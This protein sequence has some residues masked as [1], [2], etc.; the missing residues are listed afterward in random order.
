MEWKEHSKKLKELLKL[1]GSPIAITY[2]TNPA[3]ECKK[4]EFRVCDAMLLARN[5]EIINLTKE[6]SSCP[7]GTWHLGL[8]PKAS[9][10]EYRALQ[11]FLVEGEK[12]CSS[13]T[14]FHRMQTLTTPPPLD[15]AENVVFSPLEKAETMPDLVL[16]ICSPEQACRLITLVTY[17]DGVP[18]KLDWLYL[19]YGDWLSNC[20]WRDNRKFS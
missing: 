20:I 9:G 13:I 3:K 18:P 17:Y 5:G 4:G 8:G 19:P 11:K 2:S 6:N 16:F 7:G 15:L 14:V 12:L 1:K 10:K